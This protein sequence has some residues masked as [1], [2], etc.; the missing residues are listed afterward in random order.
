MDTT[1]VPVLHN[2]AKQTLNP[3]RD[4][5]ELI[6]HWNLIANLVQRDLTVRYKRSFFGFLWKR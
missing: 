2:T 5:R 3:I 1:V 6:Q 4:V